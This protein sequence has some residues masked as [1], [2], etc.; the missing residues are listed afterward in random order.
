MKSRITQ[1]TVARLYN[2]GNYEHVRFE[3]NAEVPKG[4]SP[5]QT[6]FDLAAIAQRLKP[7]KKP[8]DYDNMVK[9]LNK[10][11]E[12]L[13]EYEKS[14]IEEWRERVKEYAALKECQRAALDMLEAI[15]GTSKRTDAKK[16]WRDDEDAPW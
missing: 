3:I 16:D 1:I 11:S 7:V 10:V 4:G 14:N 8:Y 6:L 5:K 15:G 2:L 9:T 13:S 12:E